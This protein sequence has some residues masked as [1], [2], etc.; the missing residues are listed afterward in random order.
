MRAGP[1]RR[2]GHPKTGGRTKGT[3]N[4]IKP[5]ILAPTEENRHL[6]LMAPTLAREVKTP[7]TVILEAMMRFDNL[8]IELMAKAKRMAK[9]GRPFEEIRDVMSESYRFTIAAVHC[10]VQAAPYVHARLLAIESRGDMTDEQAPFVLRA[11]TVVED[12]DKWQALVSRE[13]AVL[14]KAERKAVEEHLRDREATRQPQ[15]ENNA[16]R[17]SGGSLATIPHPAMPSG[18]AETDVPAPMPA[19]LMADP[20]TSRI[21]PANPVVIKPA[22]AQEWLDSVAAA[23]SLKIVSR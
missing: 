18:S 7:K 11:P 21:M 5:I 13:S 6:T 17:V 22:G 8:S 9:S 15:V 2:K 20:K 10:A 23:R 12:S 14:D 19:P 4:K 3:K 1:G 16:P